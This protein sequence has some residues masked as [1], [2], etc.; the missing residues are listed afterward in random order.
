VNDGDGDDGGDD[1]GDGGGDGTDDIRDI[2][3]DSV[4]Q[5]SGLNIPFPPTASRSGRS[6]GI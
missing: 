4:A 3:S 1:G 6:S 5:L 2:H